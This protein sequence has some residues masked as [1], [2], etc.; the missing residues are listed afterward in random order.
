MT[1]ASAAPAIRPAR[2]LPGGGLFWTPLGLYPFQAED[3]ASA[4]VRTQPGRWQGRAIVWDT[5]LG[6]AQAVDEPVLTPQGWKRIGDIHP[7]DY[8]IGA[9]GGPTRVTSVHPQGV[10]PLYRVTFSDGSSTVC[11]E[12]HLWTVQYWGSKRVD[13]VQTRVRR[14]QTMSVRQLLDTRLKDRKSGRRK[15]SIPM[16]KPVQYAAV[17][18]PVPAYQLG[19]ILGD[20]HIR[21][22][23]QVRLS[24]DKEIIEAFGLSGEPAER[25][26]CFH[27]TT[28]LYAAELTQLGLAGKHSHEKFVPR[29]YLHVPESDRRA[30]LA[31]LLD[32]DGSPMADGGVEFCSTSEDLVDAVA[33]LVESLGGVARNKTSRVTHYTHA[34]ETREGRKSW[35]INVKLND[36]PFRLARKMIRWM[37]PSYYEAARLIESIERVEDG[38]AVCI[39]VDAADELYLTRHHIV[40]HNTVFGMATAGMLFEDD[41][42]DLALAVVERNKLADWK[43]EFERFTGLRV[44]IYHGQ[45]RRKKLEREGVPHVLVSTY[46]TLR[47]DLMG[48]EKQ[49]GRRGRGKAVDGPLMT[50]LGLREK[51][52]LWIFDEVTALQN[53]S[54]L[55]H[56]AFD[57]VLRQTRRGPHWQR[58]FGLT[59]APIQSGIEDAYNIGRIIT[60]AL[61]PKVADFERDYTKGRDPFGRYMYQNDA[62]DRFGEVFRPVCLIKHKTDE[63]VR[64][65]FP[66]RVEKAVHVPLEPA[67]RK[68]YDAVR[69]MLFSG[70]DDP[71]EER[72]LEQLAFTVLRMTAGHPASHLYAGN[73]VS[74]TIVEVMGEQGLLA[75]PSSKS[76]ELIQRLKPIV[77]GQRDQA[78][79]FTFYGQSVLKALSKDL[80]AAGYTVGEYHGGNSA[81]VNDGLKTAFKQGR[82]EILLASDAAAKGLN[83]ENAAYTFEYESALTHALR[84]Q[85]INRTHRITS[86]R[87][88]NTCYTMIAEDTVEE[89]IAKHMLSR[90][91]DH[92]A[93]VGGDAEDGYITAA[94]RRAILGI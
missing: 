9:D 75:I 27:K 51:R 77:K 91:A 45:N 48:Y 76:M 25:G 36:Q 60:P 53:R 35:R 82:F 15:F 80:Q 49:P 66:Q 16:T 43:E 54:S 94:D 67:H 68:L 93:V 3:I 74:R 90:H 38:E 62:R 81:A 57:Y 1:A 6:K 44:M 52:N 73:E 17:K 88:L 56:K 50:A 87:E 78:I 61:M 33:E 47:T 34:G 13:G 11:D 40:T 21:P 24:T 28:S 41:E 5:G 37:K 58:V 70:A 19:A 86:T 2:E 63:D 14:A 55:R 79:V 7:H 84:L 26:G 46:D 22:N 85:R 89:G 18:L 20:G 72:R 32:T 4:L 39:K 92:D 12:E 31:G 29:L 69:D 83:L 59:A 30:L 65:Q 8:V 42:I 23:G 71:A 64:D 10:R